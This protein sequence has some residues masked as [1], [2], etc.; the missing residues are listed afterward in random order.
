MLNA[1]GLDVLPKKERP[2]ID[3][4][5]E[6]GAQ[7][8]SYFQ[9]LIG[10]LRR[11]V[12]LGRVDIC[13][14]TSMMSSH[15]ALPRRGNLER[16]FH[17]FSYLKK[18]QNSEMLFYPTD[19]DVK[20]SDF[21]REDWGLSIYGDVKEEIPPIL[22]FAESVTGDIPETRGQ[23]FT[24]AVYVDCDLGGD[25]VTRRS[26]TVFAVFFNGDP[27]YWRSA[28]QKSYEVSTFR[29]EFTAMKQAVEY[30]CGI[31]YKLQ[32]IGILC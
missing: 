26:R 1:K 6:L 27:I 18:H 3:I 4:S 20:I 21:Q 29:S 23:G 25:C 8:D 31:R 16:L 2:E 24:M 30:V 28:K 12:E 19:P 5:E 32:M 10:I 22:L 14:E 15:I 17:I 7:E 9:S 11:M 13:T